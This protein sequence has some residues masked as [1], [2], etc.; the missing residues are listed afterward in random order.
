MLQESLLM[1]FL[2]ESCQK[3]ISAGTEPPGTKIK[4]PYC[5]AVVTVPLATANPAE[6][7]PAVYREDPMPLMTGKRW[8]SCLVIVIAAIGF[9]AWM[10][11]RGR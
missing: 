7:A 8:L 6:P 1:A 2:C 9:I 11:N 10:V 5:G 4:C 3:E